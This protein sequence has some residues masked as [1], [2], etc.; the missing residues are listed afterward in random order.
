MVKDMCHDPRPL[1][2]GSRAA[3]VSYVTDHNINIYITIYL[4][5]TE[6]EIN[7]HNTQ[8][9]YIKHITMIYKCYKWLYEKLG[10]FFAF[11][12]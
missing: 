3:T 7:N 5:S 6:S 12:V 8:N 4:I 2:G 10:K 11:R 1:V 9:A